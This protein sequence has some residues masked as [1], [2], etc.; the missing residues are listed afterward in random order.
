MRVRLQS[1]GRR[2]DASHGV[3]S[4]DAA[5]TSTITCFAKSFNASRSLRSGVKE[6]WDGV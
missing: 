1:T 5:D 4:E 6:V 2:A 3:H